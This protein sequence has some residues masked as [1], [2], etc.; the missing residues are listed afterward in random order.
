M[1]DRDEAGDDQEDKADAHQNAGADCRPDH[2]KKSAEPAPDGAADVKG[3]AADVLEG[4]HALIRC[5]TG[6][7][8]RS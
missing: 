5:S 8:S 1:R 6:T 2:G 4:A 3:T 7:Y